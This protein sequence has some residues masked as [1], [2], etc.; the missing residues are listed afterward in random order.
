VHSSYNSRHW[1]CGL[2]SSHPACQALTTATCAHSKAVRLRGMWHRSNRASAPSSVQG[3]YAQARQ[4]FVLTKQSVLPLLHQC[5]QP[6]AVFCR[7]ACN[8]RS[9]ECHHRASADCAR[10]GCAQHCVCLLFDLC[11]AERTT[12]AH[13]QAAAAA[14]WPSLQSGLFTRSQ[15]SALL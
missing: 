10:I 7:P 3:H 5:Q 6:P 13:A 11:L 4:A 9:T 1:A 12:G 8:V 15:R 2:S 14:C